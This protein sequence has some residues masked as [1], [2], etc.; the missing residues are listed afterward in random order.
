[1]T[2][3]DKKHPINIRLVNHA[4]GH[5]EYCVLLALKQAKENA[6]PSD[7]TAKRPEQEA[8]PY[9]RGGALHLF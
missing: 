7:T 9:R 1:M 3:K 6:Y 2:E 4:E 5:T 8:S